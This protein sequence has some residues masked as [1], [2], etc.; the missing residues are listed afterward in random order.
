MTLVSGPLGWFYG[1][2]DEAML[3]E[4]ERR[5]IEGDRADPND[6]PNVGTPDDRKQGHVAEL[7]LADFLEQWGVG[8][9][10]D[11]GPNY[12][13]DFTF[14]NG[15]KVATKSCGIRGT[16][17]PHHLVYVFS[18]HLKAAPDQWFFF[19]YEKGASRHVL[20]GGI[21]HGLF[22]EQAY[23]VEAGGQVCPGFIPVEDAWVIRAEILCSPVL[24][25]E[26]VSEA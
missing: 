4:G 25:I 11:G 14:F 26:H 13:P 1:Y 22:V 17:Q 21:S 15:C 9:I 7:H 19:A 10:H 16:F 6:M 12:L 5:R 8:Y 18:S 20:L 2:A 23:L 3:A 24:W